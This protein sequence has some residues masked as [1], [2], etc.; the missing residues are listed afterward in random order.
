[1]FRLP[2]SLLTTT[3]QVV[4]VLLLFLGSLAALLFHATATL[5]LPEQETKNR[6]RLTEASQRLTQSAAQAIAATTLAHPSSGEPLGPALRPVT[7]SIL[8][9]YPQVEGGFYLGGVQDRFLAYAFPTKPGKASPHARRDEPPPHEMPFIRLQARRSL[10][11]NTGSALVTVQDIGPSRVIFVTEPV[12]GTAVPLAGWLMYRL[13]GPEQTEGR[14]RRYQMSAGLALAGIAL[15]LVLTV[16]LARQVRRQQREQQRLREDLHRS[17]HLAAL[18]KLLAGV[19]HEVRNPLAAMRSTIQLW[20]RLPETARTPASLN[21][22]LAA[23]DRLN[24][25][26]SRLLHFTHPQQDWQTV[27]LN[28]LV[29]ET[30]ELIAAQADNQHVQ[31]QT[32]LDPH[33]PPVQGSATALRQVILNLLTNAL[34]AMPDGGTVSCATRYVSG[35]KQLELL[36]TDTGPGVPPEAREHVFE[37]FFT[38]RPDGTGLGLAL[39]REIITQHGGTIVQVSDHAPGAAFRV[40]LPVSRG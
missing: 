25:L 6:Q 30:L 22:V 26:V 29:T 11:E 39:C 14:L 19:A 33:L 21:A 4:L 5:L 17:E 37:P 13:T 28:L 18:G 8:R 15:S 10:Q 1:M 23:V 12:S 35:A 38:T 7:Q 24:A 34:Q 40:T 27:D 16:N 32:A 9:D 31:W 2:A 36:C 3:V 20:Q